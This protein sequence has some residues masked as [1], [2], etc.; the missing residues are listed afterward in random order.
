M[1]AL[2]QHALLTAM[3]EVWHRI[4]GTSP[5]DARPTS[6]VTH[7]V[8]MQHGLHGYPSQMRSLKDAI[9]LASKDAGVWV[10][11]SNQSEHFFMTH[12]GVDVLGDHLYQF[13]CEKAREAGW[14]E[15]RG[16]NDPPRRLSI[17]GHSLGGITAR[18]ALGLMHAS[19]WFADHD[20]SPHAYIS[21]ASPHVG[22]SVEAAIK[23]LRIDGALSHGIDLRGCVGC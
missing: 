10:V 20:A 15:R 13:I 22:V 1:A 11:R 2:C 14:T 6:P 8:V 18:F 17:V 12:S 23:A 19:N 3:S 21:C 4:R 5:E 9:L 7:L 16:P